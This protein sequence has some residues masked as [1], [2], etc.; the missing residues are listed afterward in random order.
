MDKYLEKIFRSLKQ[1]YDDTINNGFQILPDNSNGFGLIN[2]TGRML[3][4]RFES[5]PFPIGIVDTLPEDLKTEV[6]DLSIMKSDVIREEIRS[7][8]PV[9]DVINSEK[10]YFGGT[11]RED[12]SV[13]NAVLS[14]ASIVY[15]H[16]GS[17]DLLHSLLNRERV[18]YPTANIPTPDTMKQMVSKTGER[19]VAKN[20]NCDL[21]LIHFLY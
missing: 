21:V 15:K 9:C 7:S 13:Q 14:L 4:P 6:T 20:Y 10:F 1:K 18:L 16:C 5:L 12:T 3:K 19:Y 2:I 17:D 8:N 11:L